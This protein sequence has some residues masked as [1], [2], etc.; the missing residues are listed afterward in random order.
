MSEDEVDKR[1][2]QFLTK[3]SPE[4]KRE[5]ARCVELFRVKFGAELAAEGLQGGIDL[6]PEA[7][8]LPLEMPHEENMDERR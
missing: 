7:H 4:A 3:L 6:L 1:Y 8:S 5:W 2:Q